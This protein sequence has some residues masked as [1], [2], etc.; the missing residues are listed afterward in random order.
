MKYLKKKKRKKRTFLKKYKQN[1]QITTAQNRAYHPRATHHV[2]NPFSVRNTSESKRRSHNTK[3]K[4]FLK[5]HTNPE[6]IK[7]SACSSS[8]LDSM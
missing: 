3:D 8:H 7:S 5:S 6:G 4:I 1:K 2:V